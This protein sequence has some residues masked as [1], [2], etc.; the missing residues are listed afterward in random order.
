[1]A[2][3]ARETA[4]EVLTACRR[5]EA[6]ADGA[7]RGACRRAGLDARDSALASRLTYGV[8]QN[9]TLLDFYITAF[10]AQPAD[11][12]EPVVR[13]ILRI[14]VY[15]LL[16]LDKIPHSAAVN[17][18]V[19]MVKA[20]RRPRAAGMVNAVLRNLE[21]ALSHLPPLP[22]DLSV[23]YSH[24]RWLCDRYVDLLGR[25]EAERLLALQNQ[26]VP[27]FLQH[28][29]LRGAAGDLERALTEEGV[30]WSRHPWLPGCYEV[31]G[32]GDLEALE[33]FRRGLFLVQDP[34]ARL[35]VLAAAP[36][37]GMEVLDLCAAPGGKTFSAAMEMEDRGRI[38][39]RD[40]HPGKLR[41]I[42]EGA[43]RLGISI[44][45][46]AAGDA[47]AADPALRERF[48]LVLCD[49][50]CSGLGVIRKKPD[51][52]N[53]RPEELA[54]LPEIQGAIL[55]AAADCVR[56]GG[57]LLYATCTVLPEENGDVV[58]AFLAERRD[59]SREGFA[60]PGPAGETEGEIT[61]WPQR[62]GTDGFFICRLRRA[63]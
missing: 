23:R 42:G 44:V 45:E 18:A 59:F 31:S 7:L 62:H 56:P 41:K 38:L 2:G 63:G 22:E 33:A 9:Q 11:R 14:G 4:L 51:I 28:N 36:A 55:R 10:C 57:A 26:P 32:T 1:M 6:W 54:R 29:P 19:E 5:A 34:A 25:E 53:K 16:F 24:P 13:D 37:P 46:T 47:R 15:Q 17:R 50:P 20:H 3:D 49:V 12:L 39:A 35:A 27:M 58:A 8:V 61:L 43:R 40:I 60:L 21:R 30:T 52:R 48:D